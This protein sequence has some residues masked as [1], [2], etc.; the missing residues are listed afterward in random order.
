VTFYVQKSLATGP[1]RFGISPRRVSES[2]DDDA[3]LST[4][5]GGEF[6]RHRELF[7]SADTLRIGEAVLPKTASISSTP[8]LSSLKPDGTPRGYGFLALMIVGA[9]FVILGFGVVA[10]KGAQGWVEVILGIIMISVPIVLTAQR[11]K[12]LREQEERERVEREATEKRNR[13]MLAA[14]SSALE[15]A[16]RDPSPAAFDE[17]RRE[18]A[19][20]T[21]PY[22]IWRAVARQTILQIGFE[23]LAKLQPAGA[24]EIAQRM[25]AASEAAGLTDEDRSGVKRDLYRVTLWHLLADDRLGETQDQQLSALRG[26]FG[27]ADD[28]VRADVAAVDEFRRLRGIGRDTLPR[29]QCRAKLAFQEFCIHETSGA[30]MKFARAKKK[31]SSDAGKWLKERDCTLTITNKR[32]IITTNKAAELELSFVDD[33]M[34][35]VDTKVMTIHTGNVKKPIHLEVAD[36]IYTANIID[37]AASIDT[38]PKGFA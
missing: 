10:N 21:L 37:I 1:I 19:A 3:S 27:I 23:A 33:V 32:L 20:L 29:T 28:D 7:F 30:T 22:E 15:R 4:G 9:L 8:F 14:Y 34:V 31:K 17:L 12:Q 16:R 11:R 35:N 36:P 13:E 18:R 38:R 5:A 2:I 6:V 25:D 24:A 26:G